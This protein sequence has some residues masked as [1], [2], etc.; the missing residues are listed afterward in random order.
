M[1][2]FHISPVQKRTWVLNKLG[3]YFNNLI[4]INIK[5]ELLEDD[6]HE[7]I[8]KLVERHEILRTNFKI[9]NYSLYPLQV[10]DPPAT[11]S[12]AFVDLTRLSAGDQGDKLKEIFG[13]VQD[14]KSQFKEEHILTAILCKLREDEYKLILSLPTLSSDSYSMTQFVKQLTELYTDLDNEDLSEEE[15]YQFHQF[16]EWHNELLDEPEEEAKEFWSKQNFLPYMDFHLPFELPEPQKKQCQLALLSIKAEPVLFDALKKFS[17]RYEIP[18]ATLVLSCW[19]ILLWQYLNKPADLVI[20]KIEEGRHYDFFL[21]I[22]GPLSKTLP[23]HIQI[24]GKKN[25]PELC[26]QIQSVLD[27]VVSWQDNFNLELPEESILLKNFPYFSAGFEHINYQKSPGD[28][29]TIESIYSNNDLFKLKLTSLESEEDIQFDLSFL[30]DFFGTESIQCIQNQLLNLISGVLNNPD[31]EIQT[32]STPSLAEVKLIGNSNETSADSTGYHSI[33]ESFEEQASLR[34]D[35]IALVCEG[36][37]L[38]YRELN[39][40]ANQV[41]ARLIELYGITEGDIIPV[42]LTRSAELITAILGILKTRAAFLPL[43]SNTPVE[44]I[45]LI[46]EEVKPKVVFVGQKE[47][48]LISAAVQVEISAEWYNTASTGNLHRKPEVNDAAYVIYTSGSTGKPK[49]VVINHSSLTNYAEWFKTTFKINSTDSTL[50]FSSVAFDLCYT[51]LWSSLIS[52]S[53]LYLLQ[54][55]NPLDPAA[56]T[57]S[58]VENKITYIKLTPSHF[59]M[60]VNTDFEELV[61]QYN[62]RL[63]VIGGEQIRVSDLEKYFGY[64]KDVQFVNHYGP[65]ET[66]VGCIYKSLKYEDLEQFRS[67]TV[68]GRPISNTRIYILNEFNQRVPVGVTGEICVAGSGLAAGYLNNKEL[69]AAKFIINPLESGNLLYQT[70]DLGR[71]TAEGEI[72]F[73]GRKDSQV[74]IRGYRI[75]PGEIESILRQHVKVLNSA[76]IVTEDIFGDKELVGYVESKDKIEEQELQKYL[77]IRLPEYMIPPHI[78]VLNELPLTPNGKVNRKALPSKEE[79]ALAVNVDYEGP[80]NQVEEQLTAIWQEVLGIEKIGIRDHFFQIGGHSLKAT[81]VMSRIHKELKSKIELRNIFNY[82]TIAELSAIIKTTENNNYEYITPLGRQPH[83]DLSHAQKRLWL[84]AQFDGRQSVYNMPGAYVF[85]GRINIEAFEKAFHTLIRR[86][87]ILRTTFITAEGEPKQKVHE[88]ED[89]NFKIDFK[90]IRGESD[91]DNLK[92]LIDAEAIAPFN[93]RADPL[94]RARFLQLEEEKYLFLFTMHHIITDGWSLEIMVN[95]ILTLYDAFAN[96]KDHTLPQLKIQYKD[97]AFWQ[98]QLL[99]GDGVVK[100]KSYWND[101]FSGEL[102]VLNMATDFPRPEVRTTAGAIH[103]MIINEELTQ[104]LNKLSLEQEASLFMVLLSSVKALLFRYTDQ[105]DIIIGTPIAG[106]EHIDLENQIGLYLNSLPLR[107]GFK[108]NETFKSLLQLVKEVVLDA[109]THQSYPFDKLIEDLNIERDTSRSPL[110]D[111]VVMFDNT[112]LTG[113]TVKE[114]AGIKVTPYESDNRINTIDIRIVFR[115]ANGI[116]DFS[117]DYNKDVFNSETIRTFMERIQILLENVVKNPDIL[118]SD[119]SLSPGNNLIQN[120]ENSLDQ[121]FNLNF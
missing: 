103:Q 27:E 47:D 67:R 39:E 24:D 72:E 1:E 101:K 12:I 10:I 115:E 117:I 48:K 93:F 96:A 100:S 66:T 92:L 79:F 28:G 119:I 17:N 121:V 89:F 30:V 88:A 42:W 84:S 98:N 36:V 59:N 62:L 87:E 20:G 50:L 57:R 95:E 116:I 80:R 108:K 55:S 113:P 90:D 34:P 105:T 7:A 81:R 112:E 110:F 78:F 31:K 111:V 14:Y 120:E 38:T 56:L 91:P 71:W 54:E 4:Y 65:T 77:R 11:P 43:D 99:C 29:F 32:L 85:D 40:K 114:L 41:A 15:N 109:F 35:H 33:I 83:Y 61:K 51:S 86:H 9:L 107:T 68:I 21:N 5:K 23:V 52:G 6:L 37:S 73:L 70:G 118:L 60:I 16:S 97:Y 106:R 26:A 69:T 63:V 75:E 104:A 49:G 18:V 44:R 8:S 19:N 82:P 64:R 46:L 102:P 13:K 25:I 76:V 22:G 3:Y 74:K 2:G 94:L 58:L 45:N 53:S